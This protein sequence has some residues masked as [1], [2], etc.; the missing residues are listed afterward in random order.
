ML[1]NH[2][3]MPFTKDGIVPDIIINP[4]GV[5]SRMSTG[6]LLECI[7]GKTCSILGT[8]YDASPFENAKRARLFGYLMRSE[9]HRI[10]CHPDENR[11]SNQ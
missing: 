9:K 11:R 5:P 1:L 7:T 8:I 6:H 10:D 2:E 4:H 3:D